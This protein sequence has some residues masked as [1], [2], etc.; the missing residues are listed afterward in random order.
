MRQGALRT[1]MMRLHRDDPSKLTPVRWYYVPDDREF[2]PY[3]TPFC[4]RDWELELGDALLGEVAST[5]QWSQAPPT[6]ELAG[7]GLCGSREQWERGCLTTDFIAPINPT[8]AQKCCCGRGS[9]TTEVSM[10]LAL[11][12]EVIPPNQIGSGGLALGGSAV[13]QPYELVTGCAAFNPSPKVWRFLFPSV[14]DCPFLPWFVPDPL[15]SGAVEHS[16]GCIWGNGTTVDNYV[17]PVKWSLGLNVPTWGAGWKLRLRGGT[18]TSFFILEYT[19]LT[20]PWQQFGP[21]VLDLTFDDTGCT[22]I[23][24]T[25]TVTAG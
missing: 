24:A 5:R 20:G 12:A 16:F 14:S 2:I 3:P 21:N 23:P 4:S 18:I 13:Q 10:A 1:V 6:S 11:G 8:T 19:L 15:L 7:E 25:I 17:V 22:G 9:L